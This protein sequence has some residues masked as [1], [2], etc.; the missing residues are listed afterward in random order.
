MK[1]LISLRGRRV[2]WGTAMAAFLLSG[3]VLL[4]TKVPVQVPKG[5]LLGPKAGSR[6]PSPG[7]GVLPGPNPETR[8]PNLGYRP[9]VQPPLVKA[10]GKLPLSFEINRGQTDSRVKF[11]S[12]GSGYS[13]FLTRK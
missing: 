1:S 3:F 11:L 12:R 8:V 13:L 6:T 4:L 9:G 7:Y 5:A 10:Y 2:L